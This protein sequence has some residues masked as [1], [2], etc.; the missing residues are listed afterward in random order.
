MADVV[1][2]NKMRKTRQRAAEQQRATENRIAHGRTKAEK[3]AARRENE[4]HIALL[5]GDRLE[6]PKE[7][8]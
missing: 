5:D 2:L 4:R 8:R 6:A 1:N 3:A 7:R